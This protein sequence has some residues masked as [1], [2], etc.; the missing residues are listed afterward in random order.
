MS[1][2][3]TKYLCKITRAG[4]SNIQLALSPKS[5]TGHGYLVM[6]IDKAAVLCCLAVSVIV[7]LTKP[8]KKEVG[9]LKQS[10]IF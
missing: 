10:N 9:E 1:A 3:G 5:T 6:L 8:Q 4:D 7:V 2:E